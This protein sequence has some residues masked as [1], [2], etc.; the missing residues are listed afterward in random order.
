[1]T[2]PAATGA[3]RRHPD[4]FSLRLN[5]LALLT[6]VA[7]KDRIRHVDLRIAS[8]KLKDP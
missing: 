3:L 7:A 4:R 1:M 2:Q 6:A 8:G 5:R